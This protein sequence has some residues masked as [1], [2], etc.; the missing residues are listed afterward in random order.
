M[1][2]LWSTSSFENFPFASIFQVRLQ[3]A[4]SKTF[5]CLFSQ[6]WLIT[7]I[8]WIHES[9]YRE[10]R[11]NKKVSFGKE[12]AKSI[13]DGKLHV[14]NSRLQVPCRSLSSRRFTLYIVQAPPSLYHLV[15][16]TSPSVVYYRYHDSDARSEWGPGT[17]LPV[18]QGLDQK[19]KFTSSLKMSRDYAVN[20]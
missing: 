13:G 2:Y 16:H 17:Q 14:Q 12:I 20:F 9:G 10:W 3:C 18:A 7:K 15:T 1:N 4:H 6:N 8:P 5:W 19:S 11:N